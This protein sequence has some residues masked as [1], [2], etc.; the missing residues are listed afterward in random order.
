MRKNKDFLGP[1][2]ID[3][4]YCGDTQNLIKEIPS[5]SIDLILTDPP[6][7]IEFKAIKSNYNRKKERVIDGY[8]E[9]PKENYFNFMYEWLKEAYRILKVTGSLYVFSGWNNLKDVLN[10]I[11]E[12]NFFILNHLIWKFQF[13]YILKRNL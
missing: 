3:N 7:A 4:I 11:E 10:A 12:V 5:S 13:G 1:Y 9:I 8:N 6:F 2:K